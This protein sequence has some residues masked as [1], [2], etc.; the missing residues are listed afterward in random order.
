MR[1][2]VVSDTHG[3]TARAFA[4][5]SLCEPVDVI[6]HLGDG[7]GDAEQLSD[8]L[9]IPLVNVAGN[10]DHSVSV[11]R[12]RIWQCE[13]KRILLTHGDAYQVKSGLDRLLQRALKAGIDAVLFGHTHKAVCVELSGV[14]LINPGALANHSHHKSCAVLEITPES[15]SCRH[16]DVP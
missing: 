9:D 8:A 6:V 7:C 4:A 15:I 11:V 10:C 12:E 1:I 5:L 14:L 2:F 13:G 16:Y 3:S